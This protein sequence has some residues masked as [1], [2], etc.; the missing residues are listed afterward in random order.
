MD[1]T[2]RQLLKSGVAGLAAL[3]LP[4]PALGADARRILVVVQ[5]AGGNDGLNTLVPISDPRYRSLRPTVALAAGDVLPIRD[6]PLAL[7]SGL[8]KLHALFERGQLAILQGVGTP[9]VNRSHFESTAIWQTAR[10][11]PHRRTKVVP[12]LE[13]LVP[14]EPPLALQQA[15]AARA[16]VH[17]EGGHEQ[18]LRAQQRAP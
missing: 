16:G 4:L 12:R 13:V 2:R 18:A 5:L 9:A 8:A 7:H 14:L 15:E 11:D 6:T 1:L 3:S 17:R 10:L